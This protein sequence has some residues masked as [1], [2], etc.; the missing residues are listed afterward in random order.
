[1]GYNHHYYGEKRSTVGIG[2]DLHGVQ[3]TKLHN[4]QKQNKHA[5]KNR[6][7]KVLQEVPQTHRSQG[8]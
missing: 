8:N 2:D 3:I 4:E 1:L 7:E 6:A 5:R